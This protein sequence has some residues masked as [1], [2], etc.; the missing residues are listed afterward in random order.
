MSVGFEL[1]PHENPFRVACVEALRFRG[2][3]V[4]ELVARFESLGRRGALIGPHGTG[5]STLMREL[6][7]RFEDAGRGVETLSLGEARPPTRARLAAWCARAEPGV[8]LLLDGAEQLGRL[9][10]ARV[11]RATRR[12]GGLLVTSHRPIGLPVLHEHRTGPELLRS[13][14]DELVEDPALR[15]AL[16]PALAD[17]FDR[18]RGNLRVALRELYDRVADS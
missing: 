1:A 15:A 8:V 18:A 4:D 3:S 13:L 16:E 6:G 7:A 17:A 5:K 14:V 12:A 11:R 10:R 9:A 2:T